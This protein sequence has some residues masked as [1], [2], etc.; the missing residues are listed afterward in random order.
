[1]RLL[2]RQPTWQESALSRSDPHVLD[3]HA[4]GDPRLLSAAVGL[5]GIGNAAAQARER[6]SVV[7]GRWADPFATQREL[8]AWCRC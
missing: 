4:R 3:L 5:K 8:A 6:S 7:G 2:L 1:V